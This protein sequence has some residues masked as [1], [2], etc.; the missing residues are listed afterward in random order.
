MKRVWCLLGLGTVSALAVGCG[1][2]PKPAPVA[3]A[4]VQRGAAAA[5]A[6]GAVVAGPSDGGARQAVS[7]ISEND[8]V[9]NDRNRDPFRSYVRVE[10]VTRVTNQKNILLDQYSIDEL[11]LTAIVMGDPSRA[12]FVDPRNKGWVLTRGQ[13]VGRPETVHTGGQNGADY[14]VIWRVDR[15]RPTDVVMVREDPANPSVPPATKVI[16]LH[17]GEQEDQL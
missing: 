15:I 8:F 3:T 5:A 14:T 13:F 17:P 9:E 16:P 2:K 6:A 1:D 11:K 10:T 7:D 12:M 4:P